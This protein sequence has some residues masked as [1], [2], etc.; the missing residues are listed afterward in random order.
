[1]LEGK[2]KLLG[3]AEAE[4]EAL[5]QSLAAA[6]RATNE[7]AA[8]EAVLQK[9]D[10]KAAQAAR[11]AAEQQ[12][13]A[14]GEARRLSEMMADYLRTEEGSAVRGVLEGGEDTLAAEL[15]KAEEAVRELSA[16]QIEGKSNEEAR[17]DERQAE[18]RQLRAEQVAAQAVQERKA[19]HA[20]QQ[21]RSARDLKA[22]ANKWSHAAA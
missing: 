22:E 8:R 15:A 6:D 7:L 21:M 3:A 4:Q 5:Q 18:L 19:A 12:A 1:M 11:L 2:E 20:E 9:A 16:A 14:E 13:A 10:A 17:R